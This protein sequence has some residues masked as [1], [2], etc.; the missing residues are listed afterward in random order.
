MVLV[1]VTGTLRD[2][3]GGVLTPTQHTTAFGNAGQHTTPPR[4]IRK[5]R[6]IRDTKRASERLVKCLIS[7]VSVISVFF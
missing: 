4:R 3:Y 2:A 5:R 6:S 7:W 1:G